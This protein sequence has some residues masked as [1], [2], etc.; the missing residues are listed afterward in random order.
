MKT[1]ELI[2]ALAMTL[3][4]TT[5]GLAQE[6]ESTKEGVPVVNEI[7]TDSTVAST[8]S[9]GSTGSTTSSST[10]VGSWSVTYTGDTIDTDEAIALLE[11]AL[12]DEF[13]EGIEGLMKSVMGAATGGLILAGIVLF[14]IFILPLI[15]IIVVLYFIYKGRRAKYDAYKSMAESGQ[16]IPDEELR[17]MSEPLTDRVMFNKGV[18]N[19]CL[20]IGL[21]VLLG[22]IFGDFGIGIGVLVVCIG[23]GELLVDYFAKK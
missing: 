22:I 7:V 14:G 12:G 16:K 13:P 10:T 6:V 17:K 8:G 19:I 2:L 15:L 9:T 18:K 5:A 23:I 11:E 3:M 4:S 1:K 21:A 20:G